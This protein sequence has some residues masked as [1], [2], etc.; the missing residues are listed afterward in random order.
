MSAGTEYF[1]TPR[2]PGV[3]PV[4]PPNYD[5]YVFV[6]VFTRILDLWVV[7]PVFSNVDVIVD[8]SQGF[9][10]GMTIAV[11]DAGYYQVV[12]TTALNRMT[13]QN[14]GYA[15]N[16]LPGTGMSP[17]N[18]TTTSLPGP[19][20]EAGPQGEQGPAATVAVGSTTTSPAGQNADVTNSGTPQAAIFDFII[21]RGQ[22]GPQGPQG[23]PGQAFSTVTAADFTA[24]D[25]PT[26]KTLTLA[27][28]TGLFAQVVLNIYP[29]GY[30]RIL[31]VL[32][33]TQCTVVNTGTPGNAASGTLSSSGS[34]VLGTGPQGPVGATGPAGATGATG[35]TGPTG[36]TGAIGPTG[37]TGA[38]GATGQQGAIGPTGP[39]GPQGAIGATG[40][41]GPTGPD[42][43]TGPTGPTGTAATVTAGT[44]STGPP[45]SNALVTQRGTSA[46]R[47]FDFTIPKGDVGGGVVS[48]DT[49]NQARLGSD[50]FIYVPA[51]PAGTVQMFAGSVTPTGWLLCDGSAVS[52]TTF[53]ALFAAIGTNYGIG[54]GSTTFSLP[55]GR[56]R[57]P[58]GAGQGTG[59]TNRAL[60]A[61]VGEEA[62]QLTIAELAA[63]T[64][65][66]NAHNHTQNAHT[67]T[68]VAHA[69]TANQVGGSS[70]PG[71]AQ[72][73]P[74]T[75]GSAV[76]VGAATSSV[77][78]GINPAT[79]TNI[80]AT[81]V[82]QNAGSDTPHNNMQPSLAFNFIIKT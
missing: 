76:Q 45:G 4:D 65:L 80:A 25:P 53:A 13:I 52:R 16:L 37:P 67:H 39:Q 11:E 78:A 18:I 77:A 8:N 54:D 38:D 19:D 10:A 64:H 51:L 58:I 21:P 46:A 62:H 20:G 9:V 33:G 12:E 70:T 75:P 49:G 60:G 6:Y 22:T 35:P 34:P 74:G 7:P 66:Q 63:H 31:S 43:A 42:G 17:G 61:R 47:I 27:T 56:G 23:A 26:T 29:I 48:A 2:I 24:A 79:A 55:D 81:A 50:N 36:V 71:I 44:T 41:T 14:L 73:S 68:E 72:T 40:P 59:L 30:Y 3:R 69:H 28:T 82:N 15:N 5:G 32:S 1:I 57:T